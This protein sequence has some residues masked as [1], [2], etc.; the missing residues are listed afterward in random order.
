ML[1]PSLLRHRPHYALAVE[2]LYED[3][4]HRSCRADVL[5]GAAANAG[6]LVYDREALDDVN[7]AYRA[8]ARTGGALHSVRADAKIL[9]P[10][11]MAHVDVLALEP[12]NPVDR[13]RRADMPAGV[14][15]AE[16]TVAATEIHFGLAE[17]LEV[18]RR[19][20]TPASAVRDAEPARNAF[21]VEFPA[22]HCT[23]R[24]NGR[25]TFRHTGERHRGETAVS[26]LLNGLGRGENRNS[27]DRLAA[28]RRRTELES[29]VGVGEW[30]RLFSISNFSLQLSPIPKTRLAVCAA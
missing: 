6:A 15:A 7:R 4:G 28:R 24:E 13:H 26:R 2:A 8:L 22:I 19:R 14:V 20:K 16:K 12:R 27:L 9:L 11:R 30:N 1:L 21:D 5:A 29:R 17:A 3:R 18:R 25:R 10:D 23:G